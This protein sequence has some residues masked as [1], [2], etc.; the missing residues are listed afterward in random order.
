MWGHYVW[1]GSLGSVV[2]RSRR[3]V[4]PHQIDG[5]LNARL[6]S[7]VAAVAG[8]RAANFSGDE[9]RVPRSAERFSRVGRA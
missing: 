8:T 1:L 4:A 2:D 5:V 6:R 7:D 9:T 3:G